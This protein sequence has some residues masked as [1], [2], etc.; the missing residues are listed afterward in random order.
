MD[1]INNIVI[2]FDY[3]LET[4]QKIKAEFLAIDR[5]DI[6]IV[7]GAIK[8]LVKARRAI[9]EKGKTYRD[10]ANAFNKMVLAKEK[11]Y[12]GIIEPL[13]I[14]LKEVLEK[15]EAK[16]IMEA[17]KA[18]LPQKKDQLSVLNINQPSDDEILALDDSGWVVFYDSKFAEHKAN[19]AKIET[20]KAREV[21]NQKKIK[22]A[23]ERAKKEAEGKAEREKQEAILKAE[24]EKQD[25][26]DENNRKEKAR[27][28]EE[29]RIKKA[30]AD[31]IA[32]EAKEKAELES[33]TKYQDWLKSFGYSE[34]TKTD[35]VIE[36]IGSKVRLSKI[37]GIYIAE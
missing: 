13:E 30:E 19:L 37:L 23:E 14:E 27:L 28:D 22:E 31:Q 24:K 35:F 4:L 34:E 12:V 18:L 32:R 3:N 29:A 17:R 7:T 33:Q 6:N 11:E 1:K 8:Q 36:K 2:E 20:E 16:K 15:E 25:I 9:Q 21:E 5:T 10:D 26:I